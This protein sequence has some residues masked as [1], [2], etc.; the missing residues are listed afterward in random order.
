MFKQTQ[1]LAYPKPCLP[2]QDV[3]WTKT[4]MKPLWE[5]GLTNIQQVTSM[6][7]STFLTHPDLKRRYSDLHVRHG[8]PMAGRDPSTALEA[9][10]KLLVPIPYRPQVPPPPSYIVELSQW[11]TVPEAVRQEQDT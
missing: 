2:Q 6:D 1:T 4:F 9:T 7:G 3:G 10:R 11:E 8:Y 5:L